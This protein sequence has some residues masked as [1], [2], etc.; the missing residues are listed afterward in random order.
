MNTEHNR[1]AENVQLFSILKGIADSEATIF[2]IR[3]LAQLGMDAA[4]DYLAVKCS[5]DAEKLLVVLKHDPCMKHA[6]LL[7]EALKLERDP[8]YGQEIRFE[9]HT[10]V[11]QPDGV[12]AS[13][14]GADNSRIEAGLNLLG[15]FPE[16]IPKY[17]SA[18]E[19]FKTSTITPIKTA[20]LA[21][22]SPLPVT[23]EPAK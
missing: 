7:T 1:Q 9:I 17:A 18:I 23:S 6:G 22:G 5:G 3:A 11:R 10:R 4:R 14:L 21:L 16:L 15:D 19:G 2:P 12:V 8:I 20:A 13:L